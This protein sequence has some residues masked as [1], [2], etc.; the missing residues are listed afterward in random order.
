MADNDDFSLLLQ[1]LIEDVVE[2]NVDNMYQSLPAKVVRYDVGTRKAAVQVL[3]KYRDRSAGTDPKGLQDLP[4]I[5]GVPV[6]MLGADDSLINV[7]VKVGSK[8][9]LFFSTRSLDNYKL[10]DN[11]NPI[12]PKDTRKFSLQDCFALPVAPIPFSKAIG[13]DSS[14]LI[15]KMNV[16]T[17]NEC[18]VS[19]KPSGD[20][21]VD[22]P[23]KFIVNAA[24]EVEVNTETAIINAS[25]SVTIDSPQTTCTGEL[26]VDGGVSVGDDVNTDAGISLNGH[27]HIANLSKETSP[28][29]P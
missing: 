6:M 15:L 2:N 27:L 19:L 10:S 8:V 22:S 29:L 18:K 28:P 21:V 13:S 4:V 12:D 20:V 7:P 14:D 24:Q 9:M 5:L 11:E 3:I 23:T 17:G 16:G 1:S 26:R 25:S